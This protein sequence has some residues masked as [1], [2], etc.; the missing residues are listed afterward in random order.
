MAV[1]CIQYFSIVE[2][3]GGQLMPKDHNQKKNVWLSRI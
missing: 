2:N 3:K 1:P